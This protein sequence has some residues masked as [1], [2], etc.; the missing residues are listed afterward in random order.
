MFPSFPSYQHPDGRQC[1]MFFAVPKLS[2][3]NNAGQN[4]GQQIPPENTCLISS[5]D[6]WSLVED[7][8]VVVL[9]LNV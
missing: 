4:N 7:V 3:H 8:R 5:Y 2:S 6:K 9:A 1:L